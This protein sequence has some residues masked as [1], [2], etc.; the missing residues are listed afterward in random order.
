MDV[1]HDLEGEAA[2]TLA[3][4]VDIADDLLSKAIGLMG[5]SSLPDGYGLVFRF[6]GVGRR[7]VH[8]LFVRT[9]IDVLWLVDGRVERVETLPAWRGFGIAAAD[10]L[11]ELPQ[12]AAEG[13]EVGDRVRIVGD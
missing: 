11:V 2:R 7:S 5:K 9:A 12:G 6:S 3:T 13:V 4:D 10:T 8:M 1:V